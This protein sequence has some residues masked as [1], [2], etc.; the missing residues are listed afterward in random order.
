MAVYSS[1][2]LVTFVSG[3]LA[4]GHLNKFAVINSSGQ[5]VLNTTAQGP[6]DG[7]FGEE[8][9]ATT[10]GLAVPLVQP[11]GCIAKVVAGAA[12]ANGA[13]VGSDTVGRAITHVDAVDTVAV[14]RALQAASAAGEVISIHFMVQRSSA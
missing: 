7:I 1:V 3:S 14:G 8:I 13:L 6:V 9:T 11:D 10:A 12:I 5:A 2:R 4:A